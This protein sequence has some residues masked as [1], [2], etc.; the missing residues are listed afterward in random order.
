MEKDSKSLEKFLLEETENPYIA[1]ILVSIYNDNHDISR[2]SV[3]NAMENARQGDVQLIVNLLGNISAAGVW[4][5]GSS[6]GFYHVG[7]YEAFDQL[8][9]KKKLTSVFLLAHFQ[10]FLDA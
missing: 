8:D 4:S 7:V 2:M 1:N 9:I 3:K 6:R 10:Q 5:G